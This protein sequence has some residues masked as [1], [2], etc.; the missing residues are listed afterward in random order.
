MTKI[1]AFSRPRRSAGGLRLAGAALLLAL[2]AGCAQMPRDRVVKG[3][4]ST[5]P[6]APVLASANGS[7]FQTANGRP[8][9][10]D[11][12]PRQIGDTLV[13]NFNERLSASKTSNARANRKSSSSF[14][15]TVA[16]RVLGSALS[17][18][19]LDA[20]G[21]NEFQ[22]SGG[23][24]A[25]NTFTGSMT[26]MVMNVL[27]NGNLEVAGEKRIGINQG[28]EY[29]RFSGVVDPRKI[30]SSGSVA[31]TQVANARLEYYGDGFIDESQHM[32]WLQRLWLN[33]SPF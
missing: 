12:R 21:A 2:V 8:L 17:K 15:P 28:T 23:A 31:S 7:L 1:N 20:E 27:A 14:E 11:Q 16:P 5:T 19:S 9:F 32:G 13:V 3:P 18:L 4:T 25:S 22:G 24:D 30:E 10:E 33:I 6:V 29:V 26:V